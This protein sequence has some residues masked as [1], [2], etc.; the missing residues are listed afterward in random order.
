M[1]RT[2]DSTIEIGRFLNLPQKR[3][4]AVTTQRLSVCVSVKLWAKWAVKA[5]LE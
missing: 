4:V 2:E 1:L 3:Q 5:A